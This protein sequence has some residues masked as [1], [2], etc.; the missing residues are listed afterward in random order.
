MFSNDLKQAG[1]TLRMAA[2]AIAPL[3]GAI[4][5]GPP[6]RAV[7]VHSA[8]PAQAPAPA[9]AVV[10]G[11]L[12]VDQVIIPTKPVS[13]LVVPSGSSGSRITLTATNANVREVLPALAAAAG[14]SLVMGP[15]VKGR[16]SLYLRDVPPLEALRAVIDQAGLIVGE[17]VIAPPYGPVVFF[18]LPVNVNTASAAVLKA[19]FGVSDS[20][21]NWLVRA[22]SW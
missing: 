17:N 20:T 4:A 19:R 2:A 1:K 5:C 8:P 6:P 11:Q 18:Q 15:D 3:A 9:P 22:R 13:P 14:I 10:L 21:A 7:I 12:S 16:I